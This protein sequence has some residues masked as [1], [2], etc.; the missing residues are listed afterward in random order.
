MPIFLAMTVYKLFFFNSVAERETGF[1]T[2]VLL[3]NYMIFLCGD[4]I[5][6]D[7]NFRKM[8]FCMFEKCKKT[9][10]VCID[11]TKEVIGN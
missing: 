3:Q 9:S 2:F 4:D 11:H 5:L 6:K 10:I 8:I 1:S 7:E